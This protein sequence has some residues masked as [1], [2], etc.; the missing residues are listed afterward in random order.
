MRKTI[1]WTE[2]MLDYLVNNWESPT[3][4]LSHALG[5]SDVTVR[6]KLKSLGYVKRKGGS[7][8]DWS[9]YQLNYL[10]NHFA[11]MSASDIA[12]ELG[13]SPSTISLKAK[14]L[15]LVKSPSWSKKNYNNRYV[16]NY[17]SI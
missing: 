11:T 15:G 9:E 10:R 4:E 2:E 16:S 5:V 8:L 1:V 14:E 12:D 6:L 7:K 3:S 17:H 13:I